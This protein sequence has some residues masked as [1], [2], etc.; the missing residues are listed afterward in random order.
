MAILPDPALQLLPVGARVKVGLNTLAEVSS[1]LSDQEVKLEERAGD[2]VC[3]VETCPECW[4]QISHEAICHGTN[5]MLPRHKSSSVP[6]EPRS[7]A[8]EFCRCDDLL[9]NQSES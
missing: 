8:S 7:L 4:G 9:Y 6:D 2:L 3:V 5:G 1:K